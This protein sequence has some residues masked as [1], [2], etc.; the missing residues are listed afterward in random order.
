MAFFELSNLAFMSA[1]FSVGMSNLWFRRS[2]FCF[3]RLWG[4]KWFVAVG[5]GWL[6]TSLSKIGF[7]RAAKELE[8]STFGIIGGS[9][10]FWFFS[11]YSAGL[12]GP[13]IISMVW[14]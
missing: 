3:R 13:K 11:N 1:F 14:F 2:E 7:S 4:C 5:A 9:F 8:R 6:K 10:G 12:R